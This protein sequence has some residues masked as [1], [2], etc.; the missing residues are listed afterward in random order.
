[1]KAVRTYPPPNKRCSRY[2]RANK[3][4]Y[5][6][7]F[8]FYWLVRVYGCYSMAMEKLLKKVQLDIPSWRVLNIL[9]ERN[10]ASITEICEHAV[11]K[12]STITKVIYRMKGDGLVETNQS[13]V[14]GRITQVSITEKGR[15]AFFDMHQVIY[16]L[17]HMGFLA[18][19]VRLR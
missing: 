3:A 15:Q 1:M 14:D 7:G 12:H 4:F 18:A 8:P 2:N 13:A 11:A 5:K 17:F 9:F 16:E 19:T 10:G 6:E